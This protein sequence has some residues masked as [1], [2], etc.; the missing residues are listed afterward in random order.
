MWQPEHDLAEASNAS[1]S[2]WCRQRRS[3]CQMPG[4][5][6]RIVRCPPRPS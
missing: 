4:P 5:S 2:E 1:F 6:A 3:M